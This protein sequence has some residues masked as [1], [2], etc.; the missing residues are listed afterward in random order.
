MHVESTVGH[1]AHREEALLGKK[2]LD[3]DDLATRDQRIE[4]LFF[5]ELIHTKT[6]VL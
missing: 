3:D 4:S 1:E 6:I 5:C 2:A